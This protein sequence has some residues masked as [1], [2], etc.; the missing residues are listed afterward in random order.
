MP[1]TVELRTAEAGTTEPSS[2]RRPAR[3]RDLHPQARGD[4]HDPRVGAG[5]TLGTVRIK[6]RAGR[7]GTAP[8]N[9]GLRRR[10]AAIR[11]AG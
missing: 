6:A 9:A 5:T 11:D 2:A 7:T 8:R 4:H 3:D 1:E 10:L